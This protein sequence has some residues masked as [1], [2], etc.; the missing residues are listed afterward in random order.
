MSLWCY[1]NIACITLWTCPITSSNFTQTRSSPEAKL[2]PFFLCK[3]WAFKTDPF[4]K[5]F[6][7]KLNIVFLNHSKQTM[8]NDPWKII[9]PTCCPL[10]PP[11]TSASVQGRGSRGT[12]STYPWGSSSCSSSSI[13]LWRQET[14][15][16]YW[17][18]IKKLFLE[19]IEQFFLSVTIKKSNCLLDLG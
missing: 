16:W 8:A 4:N 17:D 5:C 10:V 15:G 14:S 7:K 3:C 13:A 11:P 2:S 12:P 6:T 18:N 19:K 1:H 9:A